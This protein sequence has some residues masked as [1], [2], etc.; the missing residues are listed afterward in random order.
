MHPNQQQAAERP[1]R[2]ETERR[3]RRKKRG[4]TVISGLKLHVDKSELDPAYEYRW[5]ND[6]PG[7]VQQMTN[8]D[9]D[10]VEG[11]GEQHVGVDSGH[12]VKAVLMRKRKDWYEDDQ[13][14]K[15]KPLDE[16]D[17]SIRRGAHH[18]EPELAG[19]VAYTPGTNSISR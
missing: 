4:S 15:M 16:I 5:V 3:E 6:T 7:R 14:E 9:W 11:R 12:S 8:D 18:K 2:A 10:K 13:K 1:N 19:E 17:A